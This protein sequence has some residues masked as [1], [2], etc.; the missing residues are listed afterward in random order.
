MAELRGTV[1]RV[2]ALDKE[3]AF[4]GM[5]MTDPKNSSYLEV[6]KSATVSP[7]YEILS[8]TPARSNRLAVDF[9]ARNERHRQARPVDAMPYPDTTSQHSVLTE[10][11]CLTLFDRWC[12]Q[13]NVVALAYLMHGWPLLDNAASQ[14]KRLLQSLRELKEHHHEALL[15]EEL[16]LL[17]LLF[18]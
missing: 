15:S 8:N 18:D 11:I 10:K 5:A 2:T 6:V 14:T 9:S 12:E 16:A 17:G 4:G 3:T 1:A 13:R 7:A